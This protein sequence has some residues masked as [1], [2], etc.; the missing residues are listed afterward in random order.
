[1][2]HASTVAYSYPADS[3]QSEFL[4][5]HNHVI[6]V[7]TPISN[8]DDEQIAEFYEEL[9]KAIPRTPKNDFLIVEDYWNAKVG[10]DAYDNWA[11]TTGSFRP[12]ETNH[13]GQRLL[14]FARKHKYIVALT[15]LP[16]KPFNQRGIP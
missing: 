16:Q 10:P 1:M 4:Q 9:K 13:R 8:H 12:G 5:N 3:F 7:Y 11:G 15:L 6:Q 2:Y 14:E